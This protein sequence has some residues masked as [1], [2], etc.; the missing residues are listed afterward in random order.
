MVHPWCGSR[1]PAPL[2]AQERSRRGSGRR[3]SHGDSMLPQGRWVSRELCHSTRT[4]MYTR[5]REPWSRMLEDRD[6]V[7]NLG[8]MALGD[9]LGNPHDVATFLLLELHKGIENTKVELVQKGQLV[10]F[11]LQTQEGV[12]CKG[13]GTESGLGHQPLPSTSRPSTHLVLEESVL[14]GLVSGVAARTFE[15]QLILLTQES[16][17]GAWGKGKHEHESAVGCGVGMWVPTGL[18]PVPQSGHSPGSSRP[19]S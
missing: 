14:Q 5:T 1:C 8:P 10:Q 16:G 18:P 9:A 3:G 19:R 6:V 7:I 11:H 13:L 15:K 4:H 12:V 2:Q 17:G